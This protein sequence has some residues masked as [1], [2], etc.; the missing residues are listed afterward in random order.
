M[1]PVRRLLK[2]KCATEIQ[3]M[4][5]DG[6]LEVPRVLAL[7]LYAALEKTRPSVSRDDLHQFTSWNQEF[8]SS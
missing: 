6:E 7:D 5:A 2:N 4:R 8:G 1:M 3:R